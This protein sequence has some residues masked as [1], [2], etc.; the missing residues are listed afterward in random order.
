MNEFAITTAQANEVF[1]LLIN[2]R[3]AAGLL[4]M[5]YK[6][7]ERWARIGELPGYQY[8]SGEP[9]YFRKS[10]LDAWLRSKLNSSSQLHRVN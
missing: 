3:Q 2:S 5:N 9:W 8:S 1:E 10:E 4:H 7:V 6:T